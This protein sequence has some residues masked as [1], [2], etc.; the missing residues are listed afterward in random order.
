MNGRERCSG[1]IL[2]CSS[3]RE[4][5]LVVAGGYRLEILQRLIVSSM[6]VSTLANDLELDQSRVSTNL[7]FL[8]E[9]NLVDVTPIKKNRIY[10][11]GNRISGYRN[12]QFLNLTI[13]TGQ[14]EF[15]TLRVKS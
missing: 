11:L 6:D 2:P 13:K 12:D 3:I 15:L 9:S 5:M 8:R 4:L 1:Q 10:T 14:D 7:R